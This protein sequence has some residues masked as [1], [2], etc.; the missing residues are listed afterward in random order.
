[1]QFY[2][3]YKT[4]QVGEFN[5]LFQIGA[6][7]RRVGGLGQS[8]GVPSHGNSNPLKDLRNG[9]PRETYQNKAFLK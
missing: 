8:A 2:I 5:S 7:S 9:F 1:M 6:L 4:L 3:W